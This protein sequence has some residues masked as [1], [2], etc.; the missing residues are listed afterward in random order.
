MERCSGDQ[1]G[2][3]RIGGLRTALAPLQLYPSW[4]TASKQETC[5]SWANGYIERDPEV[6][7]LDWGNA[8]SPRLREG[9]ITHQPEGS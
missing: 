9:Y 1:T 5:S 6:L 7:G 3:S 8:R 4:S 2:R